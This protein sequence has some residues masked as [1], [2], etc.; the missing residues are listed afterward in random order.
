MKYFLLIITLFVSS[1]TSACALS[2]AS[3]KQASYHYQMGLSFLGEDN[4]TRA[5][6]EF[7]EA[8]KITPD[9]PE[10]LYYLGHVYLQKKKLDVAEQKLRRAIELK[11]SYSEAKNNLGVV[12]ME[13]K[14][15]DDAIRLFTEVSADIFYQNPEI[16]QINLGLAYFGKGDNEKAVSTLRSAVAAYPRLPQ[17]RL[18]LG[19]VYAAMG[20]NDLAIEEY[21]SALRIYGGYAEAHYNLALAYMKANQKSAAADSFREV[22]RIAPDLEISQISREYLDSMK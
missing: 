2:E 5:L 6:V 3:K 9:D 19:R 13:E 15:W 8:E 4:I 16:A 7:T 10:L 12:C 14:R 20:K 18:H 21:K 17:G 11:P 22:I 1:L